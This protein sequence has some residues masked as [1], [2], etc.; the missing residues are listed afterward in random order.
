MMIGQLPSMT[1]GGTVGGGMAAGVA[2]TVA[3]PAVA[4]AAVGYGIYK[5]AKWFG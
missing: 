2:I 4:A 1:I 3:A 5:L